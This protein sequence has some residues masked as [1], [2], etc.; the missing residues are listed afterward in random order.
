[1]M[2]ARV[3]KHRAAFLKDPRS[4]P[5]QCSLESSERHSDFEF[6]ISAMV[7]SL[8]HVMVKWYKSK[9]DRGPSKKKIVRY[10]YLV[11][12]HAN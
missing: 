7:C 6:Q 4:N 11:L 1:M 3:V 10:C 12:I 2:L 9:Y 8:H 5:V